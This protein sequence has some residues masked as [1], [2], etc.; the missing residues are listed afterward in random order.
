[1]FFQC[2]QQLQ[3]A[4]LISVQRGSQEEQ[5]AEKEEPLKTL[6]HVEHSEFARG[7]AL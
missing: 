3:L 5:L 1:M 7:E 6:S 4:E 2:V